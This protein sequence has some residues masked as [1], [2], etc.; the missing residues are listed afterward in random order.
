MAD[1]SDAVVKAYAKALPDLV[2]Y[3]AQGLRNTQPDRAFFDDKS[4]GSLDEIF[5]LFDRSGYLAEL[6]GLLAEAHTAADWAVPKLQME[7]LAGLERDV[8]A[9][10]RTRLD[11]YR[12]ASQQKTLVGTTLSAFVGEVG[13]IQGQQSS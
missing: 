13:R 10:R 3:A 12:A 5:A 7:F 4:L 8:R 9:L 2:K 1:D 6:K 11:R